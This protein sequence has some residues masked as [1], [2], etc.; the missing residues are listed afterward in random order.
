MLGSKQKSTGVTQYIG[1]AGG[2]LTASIYPSTEINE[3]TNPAFT[4]ALDSGIATSQV[5]ATY[6]GTRPANSAFMPV[7]NL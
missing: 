3:F 4:A 6:A 1:G 7:I 2:F 5:S